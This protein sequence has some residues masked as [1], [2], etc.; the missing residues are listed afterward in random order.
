MS[1]RTKDREAA[2]AGKTP[3]A[4]EC[5]DGGGE[6]RRGNQG[7]KLCVCGEHV[8]IKATAQHEC[9]KSGSGI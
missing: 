2:A 1:G 6:P 4:D 3:E 7:K 8:H 5:A 9:K